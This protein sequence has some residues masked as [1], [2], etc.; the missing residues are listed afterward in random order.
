MG[1]WLLLFSIVLI[2]APGIES[3]ITVPLSKRNI[4][5]YQYLS[6]LYVPIIAINLVTLTITQALGLGLYI[7]SEQKVIAYLAELFPLIAEYFIFRW[8]FARLHR[9]GMFIEAFSAKQILLMT[10]VANMVTFSMGLG[11]IYWWGL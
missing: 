3:V 10:I 7:L 8:L 2:S 9:N 1:K 11:V 5:Q 4:K 6:R